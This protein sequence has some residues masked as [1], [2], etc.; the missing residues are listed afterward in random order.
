MKRFNF[1]LPEELVQTLKDMAKQKD[2]THSDLIRRILLAY[3][4]QQS[5]RNA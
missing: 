2:T 4:K 1:Y 5:N 3:V